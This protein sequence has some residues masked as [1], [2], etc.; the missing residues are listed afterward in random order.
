MTSPGAPD[1]PARGGERE[2]LERAH[3]EICTALT[4]F[5]SNVE[6]V[7]IQLRDAPLPEKGILVHAHLDELEGAAQRLRDMAHELKRWHDGIPPQPTAAE[8]ARAAGKQG[9]PLPRSRA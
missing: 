3:D 8:P 6:L 4:V 9:E 7:R 5:C 2:R 1:P